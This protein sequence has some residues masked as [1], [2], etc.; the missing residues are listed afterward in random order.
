MARVYGRMRLAG[1]VIWASHLRE[2]QSEEPVQSGKGGGPTRIDYRYTISFA[3]GLCGRRIKT[4][5]RLSVR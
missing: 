3:I 1:Q 2:I 5:I 4:L